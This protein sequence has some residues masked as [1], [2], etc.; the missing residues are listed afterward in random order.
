[1]KRSILY[2]IPLCLLLIGC[3]GNDNNNS[4]NFD[5]QEIDSEIKITD[6]TVMRDDNHARQYEEWIIRIGHVEYHIEK[7]EVESQDQAKELVNKLVE[8][9][10]TLQ[11]LANSAEKDFNINIVK[12]NVKTGKKIPHAYYDLTSDSIYMQV[13]Q[14]DDIYTEAALAEMTFDIHIPWLAFGIAGKVSGYE[15][16]AEALN[17]FY[18]DPDNID[19][20]GLFGGRFFEKANNNKE[21]AINTAVSFYRYLDDKYGEQIWSKVKSSDIIENIA[22]DKQEWLKSIDCDEIYDYPYSEQLMNYPCYYNDEYDLKVQSAY[23]DFYVDFYNKQDSILKDSFI[24]ERLLNNNLDAYS[25]YIELAQQENFGDFLAN[26]RIEF[27]INEESREK[28]T[29]TEDNK[30]LLFAWSLEYANAHELAHALFRYDKESEGDSGISL[31]LLMEGFATYLSAS[32]PIEDATFS[33]WNGLKNV[34]FD[35]VCMQRMEAHR[36]DGSTYPEMSNSARFEQLLWMYYCGSGSLEK[37]SEFNKLRYYDSFTKAY[38]NTQQFNKLNVD[39][40]YELL[41]SFTRFLVEKYSWRDVVTVIND[42]DSY[43][44]VSGKSFEKLVIE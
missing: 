24:L 39:M 11:K 9:V 6:R 23:A 5:T 18:S 37:Q 7:S 41:A 43:E 28:R 31:C 35:F 2:I 19:T 20:L 8:R 42:V 25:R 4:S 22:A 15:V 38:L 16:D 21:I 10:E 44:E 13:D 14:T 30:I 40:P 3:H 1:M 32:L 12:S 26:K 29:V 33:D 17:L 27:Y 36:F 34:D